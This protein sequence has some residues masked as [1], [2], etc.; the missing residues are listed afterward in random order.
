MIPDP[1][2][3]R[4]AY[5]VYRPEDFNAGTKPASGQ[6][7][8]AGCEARPAVS[9]LGGSAQRALCAAHA[10]IYG[11]PTRRQIREAEEA[12]KIYDEVALPDAALAEASGFTE[13][14][15]PKPLR[16]RWRLSILRRY[17]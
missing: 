5:A 1:K 8:E 13:A 10:K 15:E 11:W 12:A 4:R 16:R 6:C 2:D 9:R 3:I 7:S 17:V 14:L